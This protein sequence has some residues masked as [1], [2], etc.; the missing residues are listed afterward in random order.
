[1]LEKIKSNHT[2]TMF[3]RLR[4]RLVLLVMVITT[5]ILVVAF[6]TIY[7]VATASQAR[8]Y[9]V[10][11]FDTESSIQEQF[12]SFLRQQIQKERQ[13]SQR[14]LLGTLIVSGICIE[15]AVFCMAL[16]I[17]EESIRPIRDTYEAQKEFVANA[18]HEMKTPLAA[19]QANLEAADIQDN[20]WID[21]AVVKVEELTQLN[22][23]LLALARA[24]AVNEAQ[25][26]EPVDLGELMTAQLAP[27]E[28]QIQERK[29]R[30]QIKNQEKHLLTRKLATGDLKQVINILLD[31]AIK[32][33]QRKIIIACTHDQISITNDGATISAEQLPHIF[34]RFYQ[35]DKNHAGVGLGL[36]IARQAAER[37]RWRLTAESDDKTTTFTLKLG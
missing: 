10:P 8:N 18:S 23:Q 15:L 7:L 31:N 14:S 26:L 11:D 34:E 32:Y 28:P 5:V 4:N 12:E 22:N 27:F 6:A 36:A 1:M 20:H 29:L 35:T 19:I 9:S 3:N 16:Y 25:T 30:V 13:E 21:N 17:A 37:N 33:A 24:G 2:T